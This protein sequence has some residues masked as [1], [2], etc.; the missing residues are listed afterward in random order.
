MVPVRTKSGRR[1]SYAA[2]AI[3]DAD[4]YARLRVPYST[5]GTGAA[6][7]DGPYTV[8]AGDRRWQVDVPDAAVREGRSLRVGPPPE[9]G[10]GS[11]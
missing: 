6:A 3:A 7:T 9:T 4:G 11:S 10:A 8:V 5:D 1:F 2:F